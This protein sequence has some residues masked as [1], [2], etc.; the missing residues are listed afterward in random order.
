MTISVF[1]CETLGLFQPLHSLWVKMCYFWKLGNG[2]KHS[3]DIWKRNKKHLCGLFCAA[4]W[5]MWMCLLWLKSKKLCAT[6]K[7]VH[8]VASHNTL[9]F[10][11]LCQHS[12]KLFSKWTDFQSN[13]YL[14]DKKK[15]HMLFLNRLTVV[16]AHWLTHHLQTPCLCCCLD[17]YFALLFFSE[18]ETYSPSTFSQLW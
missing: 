9:K 11:P 16:V 8:L 17:W 6:H 3:E 2:C 7:L 1:A 14:L 13:F 4:P 5:V 12:W 18:R 15:I 10:H